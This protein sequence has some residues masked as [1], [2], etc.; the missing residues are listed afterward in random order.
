M[1]RCSAPA[2]C[3]SQAGRHG[4]MAMGLMSGSPS[5]QGEWKPKPHGAARALSAANGKR[6]IPRLICTGFFWTFNLVFFNLMYRE[7][8]HIQSSS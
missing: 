7:K 6:S 1:P 4:C 5:P 3:R 8:M 2:L